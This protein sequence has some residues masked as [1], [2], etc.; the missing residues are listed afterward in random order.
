MAQVDSN[1]DS[2]EQKIHWVS[3]RMK[4][5]CKHDDNESIQHIK[6]RE[7]STWSHSNCGSTLEI[8]QRAQ[9]RC[10]SHNKPSDFI[11]WRF[12]CSKHDAKDKYYPVDR[13]YMN[14]ALV[15]VLK[16]DLD[17]CPEDDIAAL[18]YMD[19]VKAIRSQC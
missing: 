1:S 11:D 13:E 5:P 8:N 10:S 4:C 9:I 18:W 14:I 15:Q 19:L 6:D 2:E 3:L 16:A 7:T 17:E 12:R